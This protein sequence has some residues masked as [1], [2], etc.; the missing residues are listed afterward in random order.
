MSIVYLDRD[1][2]AKAECQETL[3]KGLEDLLEKARSGELV[4]FTGCGHL[5]TGDLMTCRLGIFNWRLYE[6]AG[7]L[8]ALKSECLLFGEESIQREVRRVVEP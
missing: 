4:A 5:E 6:T 1:Q 3:V 2:Q 8:E 7:M